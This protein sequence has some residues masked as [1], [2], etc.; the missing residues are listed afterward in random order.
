MKT[1]V[2]HP[3][4]PM[5]PGCRK[6]RRCVICRLKELHAG[7]HAATQSS[8]KM[9]SYKLMQE[10]HQCLTASIPKFSY[11]CQDYSRLFSGSFASS[12]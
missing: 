9:T 4:R 10:H 2:A 8:A 1:Q 7:S 3:Q 5:S 12:S 6:H 11:Y